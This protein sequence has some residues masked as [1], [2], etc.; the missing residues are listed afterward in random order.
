MVSNKQYVL[1]GIITLAVVVVLF[2][3]P[4]QQKGSV[5]D[6]FAGYGTIKTFTLVQDSR[7]MKCEM[8][9]EIWVTYDDGITASLASFSDRNTIFIDDSINNQLT[10]VAN[11]KSIDMVHNKLFLLCEGDAMDGTT[12]V[13]GDMRLRVRAGSSPEIFFT[14]N[15][16]L[17]PQW[18]L[19]TIPRKV[20]RDNI[21]VEVYEYRLL[22]SQIDNF[23][24]LNEKPTSFVKSQHFKS[25][26]QPNL[27]FDFA[28]PQVG[29]F[30]GEFNTQNDGV[31]IIVQYSFNSFGNDDGAPPDPDDF[32]DTDSDGIID[33]NDNCP[34]L[35]EVWNDWQDSDGCPDQ[36]PDTDS[37]GIPD[38]NDACPFLPENFNNITDNDGC[39][40]ENVPEDTDGDGLDDSVDQ[41][42]NEKETFNGHNDHDGCPDTI[43]VTL[44]DKDG[45]GI[46]DN[47]D[48]C[49]DD[50]ED[51]NGVNDTDGCPDELVD[52]DDTN[53]DNTDDTPPV[54]DDDDGVPDDEDLCLNSLPNITVD[55]NGCKID[56]TDDGDD[57]ECQKVGGC[58]DDTTTD[59]NDGTENNNTTFNPFGG[60]SD[61]PNGIILI[62]VI[63]VGIIGS[64]IVLYKRSKK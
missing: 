51:F 9:N 12:I 60:T 33:A 18:G 14:G 32:T 50:P 39:P 61:D 10:L 49:P 58:D 46:P 41:C 26:M 44:P 27:E 54:D 42:P 21:K 11:G 17:A 38:E 36:L 63:F 1:V 22:V 52:D 6:F 30:S 8:F 16:R 53:D 25:E 20:I 64:T 40:D 24:G 43:D 29:V 34:T 62:L 57:A 48:L 31:P 56:D 13:E 35:P 59:D 3:S 5:D 55:S 23:L 19:D 15:D 45:D 2:I 7:S 28:H 37:D 4:F 47:A